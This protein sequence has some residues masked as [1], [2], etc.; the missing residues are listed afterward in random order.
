MT[1]NEKELARVCGSLSIHLGRIMKAIYVGSNQRLRSEIKSMQ[2]N[3]KT[4][5]LI[6]E[7]EVNK[8]G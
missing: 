3:L 8:N 5:I 1:K 7:S 2:R 4:I 6:L